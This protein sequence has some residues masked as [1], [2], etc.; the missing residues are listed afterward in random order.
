MPLLRSLRL[1]RAAPLALALLALVGCSRELDDSTPE[2]AAGMFL[3]AIE[4]SSTDRD[5]LRRAYEVID[6]ESQ[7][8]LS[9]RARSATALGAREY[10]PWEMIVHGRALLRFV[11]QRGSGLRARDGAL[12]DEAIV[13]VT[14][15]AE[16]QRAEVPMR[17]EDDG[18][19]VVL[20]VPDV[21][22]RP[23]ADS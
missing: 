10:E 1:R 11:P 21:R 12:E 19:R 16:G 22:T 17:L 9:E 5:A 7:R 14:G 3:A 4:Q 20:D 6:S 18:W 2:G 23:A 15:E 13:V 8:R